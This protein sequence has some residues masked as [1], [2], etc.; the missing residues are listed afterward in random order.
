MYTDYPDRQHSLDNTVSLFNG[1]WSAD[2][3]AST[4]APEGGVR[5]ARY[6]IF[7]LPAASTVTIDLISGEDTYLY[8][9]EGAGQHGAVAGENDDADAA[10]E[11]LESRIEAEL[12]AGV[13][14]IE[15]TTYEPQITGAFQIIL[16]IQ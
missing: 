5:Y 1:S 13:Y 10:A 11:I 15:A 8:L 4:P 14:T 9:K 6:Y 2:C 7:T 16:T 3:E 12:E